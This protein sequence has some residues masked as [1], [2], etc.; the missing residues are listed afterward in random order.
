MKLT[1]ILLDQILI[2]FVAIPLMA[3]MLS[4]VWKNKQEKQISLLVRI[5]KITYLAFALLFAGIWIYSGSRMLEFDFTTLY[6]TPNFVFALEFHYD[7]LSLVFSIVGAVLFFM[8]TTFSKFYLHRDEGFKRFFTTILLF[9]FGYNLIIFSGN[10][11]TLFV[12][13]EIIG[14]TSFLLIAFYRHRYLP[15]KNA[16]KTLSNYRLSDVAFILVMWM[17]H[18][19]MHKNIRFA[20]LAEV[21]QKIS[22]DSNYTTGLF[23]AGMIMLAAVIKSAQFPFTSWL[24]RS[25]EG[26]TSSTAIFYGSLSVHIGVFV[27]LRTA[28]LWEVLPLIKW[29]I[30]AFGAITALIATS[31]SRIQ[32]S[33]KTQIAYSAAAQIGLMFIEVAMGWHT[34]ALIHFAGNAFLRTYQLL[35]SPSVLNYLLHH[36]IFHYHPPQDKP[37][38]KLKATLYTLGVKE[39]NMDQYMFRFVWSPFKWIGKRLNFLGN[40][41]SFGYILLALCNRGTGWLLSKDWINASIASSFYFTIAALFSL[42]AFSFRGKALS[43][44]SLLLL[45][46]VSLFLGFSILPSA[47]DMDILLYAGGILAAF[48]TGYLTLRFTTRKYP[49]ATLNLYSGLAFRQK[50]AALIFLLAAIGM[51]GFPITTAF[52]GID[53]LFTYV[54]TEHVLNMVLLTLTFIFVELAAIRIYLRIY[55]GPYQDQHGPTSFRSS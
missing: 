32:T 28:P 37:L 30:F 4:L 2:V 48:L 27:L 36:Q 1:E 50:K 46:H 20:E 31:I 49:D 29:S 45:V 38:S 22:I 26:P 18:H 21:G 40:T 33:V 6:K 12:G 52:I 19:F 47:L 54:E 9:S 44:W 24:P 15:V 55:L 7:K 42:A 16:L 25:M 53:V 17:T 51:I 23:I 41:S 8:V 13:W 43:A 14:L 34:L 3:F 10:F 35:V 5:T 39:W 11:E